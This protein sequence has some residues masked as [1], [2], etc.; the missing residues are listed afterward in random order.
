MAVV[1]IE[2]RVG[3]ESLDLPSPC[4]LS[5][6]LVVRHWLNPQACI[7]AIGQGGVYIHSMG[8]SDL[9]TGFQTFKVSRQRGRRCVGGPE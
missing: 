4:C 7:Y 5:N 3:G 8:R 1:E 9:A 6:S 2:G